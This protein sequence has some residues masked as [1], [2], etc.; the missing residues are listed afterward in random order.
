MAIKEMFLLSFAVFQ[1]ILF[2]MMFSGEVIWVSCLKLFQETY[3]FSQ[4]RKNYLKDYDDMDIL[5][6]S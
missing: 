4:E 6:S 3:T 5:Y 1:A 2:E